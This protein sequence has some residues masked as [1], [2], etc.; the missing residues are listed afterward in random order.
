MEFTDHR[1]GFLKILDQWSVIDHNRSR[2]WSMIGNRDRD[3]CAILLCCRPI[4][5]FTLE[6]TSN[7]FVAK[8]YN[9]ATKKGSKRNHHQCTLPLP[10]LTYINNTDEIYRTK[11][12]SII[13]G[14]ISIYQLEW[15]QPLRLVWVGQMT[16]GVLADNNA[17]RHQGVPDV[18][19]QWWPW[20]NA[21]S[22]V[23]H[24]VWNRPAR[25]LALEG[26]SKVNTRSF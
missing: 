13:V 15:Q 24:R 23:W 11:S 22:T 26:G 21:T 19:N 17:Q 25:P 1:G 20:M 18:L 14:N 9:A 2:S 10:S 16:V 6:Y 7:V 4:L 8:N 12:P 3:I 5:M